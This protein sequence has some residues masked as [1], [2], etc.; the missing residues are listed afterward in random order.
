[1]PKLRCQVP[2]QWRLPEGSVC[3]VPR[4]RARPQLL[5]AGIELFFK[6]TRPQ[7]QVMGQL[8]K[9]GRPPA[10]VMAFVKAEDAKRDPYQPCPCGSGRKFK[11]CHGDKEPRSPF[12]RDQTAARPSG[13]R[14]MTENQPPLRSLSRKG[15]VDL[16]CRRRRGLRSF[17]LQ[18][19]RFQDIALKEIV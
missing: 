7:M 8:F 9:N 14:D 19:A 16:C 3:T 1:M 10:D 2:L 11:F 4:R 18:A 15:P 13:A 17:H 5:C 12:A 6:H